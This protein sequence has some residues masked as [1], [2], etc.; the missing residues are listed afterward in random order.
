VLTT[1]L[2]AQTPCPQSDSNRHWTD[3]KNGRPAV[4]TRTFE[5]SQRG[6]GIY[7]FVTEFSS[8]ATPPPGANDKPGMHAS[9][10]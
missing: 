7:A 3:F 6:D 2:P 4:V 9:A 1:H 10:K 8:W 5:T